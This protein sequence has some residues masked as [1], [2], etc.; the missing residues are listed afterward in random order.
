MKD[1]RIRFDGSKS[2]FD[3]NTPVEGKDLSK[4]KVFLNLATEQGSDP[5]YPDRGTELLSQAIG[6]V[7]I[8]N[9]E[10]QHCGNFAALDTEIFLANTEYPDVAADR[11]QSGDLIADIHVALKTLDPDTQAVTFTV[12][13]TFQDGTTT[14]ETATA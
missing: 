3:F 7:M 13:F 10:A 5:L 2:V 1:I 6:G 8:S 4:Q 11:T 14:D 12:A 9:T